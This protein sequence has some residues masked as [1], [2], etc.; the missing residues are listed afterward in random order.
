MHGL[1]YHT[2]RVARRRA[3]AQRKLIE[4]H[5]VVATRLEAKN[6]LSE[7]NESNRK[8]MVAAFYNEFGDVDGVTSL[9]ASSLRLKNDP[10]GSDWAD[11]L[12]PRTGLLVVGILSVL[13]SSFTRFPLSLSYENQNKY[14]F[15]KEELAELT[16]VYVIAL[17]INL[18]SMAFWIILIVW[19][20]TITAN[21][22]RKEPFLSTRHAQ[23]AFRVLA[24]I[25][26]L[27]LFVIA[28]PLFVQIDNLLVKWQIFGKYLHNSS[29]SSENIKIVSIGAHGS[30]FGGIIDSDSVYGRF[31]YLVLQGTRR[32][33]FAN[34]AA[35][36][37]PGLLIYITVS[38]LCAAFIFLPSDPDD[39]MDEMYLTTQEGQLID[40][41]CKRD[42]RHVV[43]LGRKTYTWRI[44]PLAIE[45]LVCTDNEVSK[46]HSVIDLEHS[47]H[48]RDIDYQPAFKNVRH[49]YFAKLASSNEPLG[50]YTPVFCLETACWLLECSWQSYY[51]AEGIRSEEDGSS[52]GKQNLEALGLKF[53]TSISDE[54]TDTWVY[55]CS[56]SHDQVDG[57]EDSIIVVSF[58]GTASVKNMMNDLKFRLVALPDAISG[59]DGTTPP[60]I[61]AT[62]RY[63]KF[64][65]GTFMAHLEDS[66]APLTR[67]MLKQT[68]AA[69]Q[70]LPCIHEGFL[71]A[72]SN[73][74]SRLL[75]SVVS[76][77][78]RQLK[79]SIHRWK[80]STEHG[81]DSKAFFSL[82]KIY[83][84]GHSL[85]GSLA[86]ILALDLSCN[87]AIVVDQANVQ[88]D[89]TM[90]T[91][92]KD[93]AN[94]S[95]V[96]GILSPQFSSSR[97][98]FS[99]DN[100]YHE[101][102]TNITREKV[103]VPPIAVYTYGQTRVGNRAFARLY[104]SCVP[105]TFRVCVEGDAITSQPLGYCSSGFY[106]HAGI[107]VALD[108][109]RTGN[110][111]VGPTIVE[112][113]FRFSKVRTSF[114]AHTMKR[115]RDCLESA[116]SDEELEE[117]YKG[118]MEK[119]F[120]RNAS[121]SNLK[122]SASSIPKVPSWVIQ[123]KR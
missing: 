91:S 20:T 61:F 34:T 11:F 120:Q 33:P 9:K 17:T 10:C 29:D 19:N 38:C 94:S 30:L 50:I 3:L 59:M 55:V 103:L 65:K 118:H 60:S 104:K 12:L 117:Y 70:A 69:K 93:Q 53:E 44:F 81:K 73:I 47:P 100:H 87:F 76:L 64:D 21:R 45:R 49:G 68:P 54:E 32:L 14:K 46:S 52:S 74:R 26:F 18:T 82:P 95:F 77:Y 28:S 56:N 22:L 110:I 99:E 84:T 88:D 115:Y 121:Q 8:N 24:S 48:S 111:L 89:P 4:L 58:R 105:H 42:K 119:N 114:E 112:T 102:K 51:S 36:M 67:K 83:L 57:D 106:K 1:R 122:S 37:G 41:F 35:A 109:G 113:L 43:T 107:E 101:N 7:F 80:T 116:F 15:T 23:L 86:Q 39:S 72:Y 13:F 92:T 62:D 63:L 108:E 85:G 71:I 31:C 97:S 40:R 79:K 5:K 123:I 66:T 27:G 25:Q 98:F 2:A 90:F 96:Q 78:Q 6:S 16:T 75:E